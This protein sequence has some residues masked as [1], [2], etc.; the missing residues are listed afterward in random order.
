MCSP[1]SVFCKDTNG[2]EN[3]SQLSVSRGMEAEK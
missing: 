3:I 1:I 2:S